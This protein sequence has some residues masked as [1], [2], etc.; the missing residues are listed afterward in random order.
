MRAGKRTEEDP[1]V[2]IFHSISVVALAKKW[3]EII[4]YNI[5]SYPIKS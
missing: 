2:L 3:Q 4:P 5:L 1:S